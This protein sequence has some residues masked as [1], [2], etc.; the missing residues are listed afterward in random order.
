MRECARTGVI[1]S[2]IK[3]KVQDNLQF[4][5]MKRFY[6]PSAFLDVSE[7]NRITRPLED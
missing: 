3:Y 7:V 2:N 5:S 4:D 1:L 6:R